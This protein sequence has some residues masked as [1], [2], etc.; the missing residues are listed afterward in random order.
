LIAIAEG[1]GADVPSDMDAEAATSFVEDLEEQAA[2]EGAAEEVIQAA[3]DARAAL[4]G[5]QDAD[6]DGLSSAAENEISTQVS[7]AIDATLP[8]Q[9]TIP[10]IDPTNEAT[11]GEPDLG[12]ADVAV[13]NWE[14]LALNLNV[15]TNNIDNLRTGAQAG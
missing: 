14:T 1:I 7:A 10:N 5:G 8:N 11:S 6:G 13:A 15:T 9:A 2:A 3:T 4:D 12:V